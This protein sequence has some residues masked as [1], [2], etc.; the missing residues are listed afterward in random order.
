MYGND[1]E[2]KKLKCIISFK[3]TSYKM[4]F[5]FLHTNTRTDTCYGLIWHV[6]FCQWG[7]ALMWKSLYECCRQ[8]LRRGAD[9]RGGCGGG[10]WLICLYTTP[11]NSLQHD[12][13]DRSRSISTCSICDEAQFYGLSCWA[14]TLER[15]AGSKRTWWQKWRKTI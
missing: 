7:M 14:G 4:H 12:G 2:K 6:L 1:N 8:Q 5:Y 11:R 10:S 15:A 9:G 3:M 13:A